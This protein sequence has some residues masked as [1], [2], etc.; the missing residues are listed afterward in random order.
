MKNIM[1]EQ[2][3]WDYYSKFD[4]I[5]DKY[6]P[7]RGEGETIASQIVTAVN[8]L[9]YKWYNDG[10][11]YDNTKYLKGWAN[12]L[13]SYANWLYKHLGS[14]LKGT[15]SRIFVDETED[16]YEE[17]LK[18][19]A[20]KTLDETFLSKFENQPKLG[21][22][23]ECDGP[24]KFIDREDE[25]DE[26]ELDEQCESK[27]PL[28]EDCFDDFEEIIAD[29]MPYEGEGE[30]MSSQIAT[31]VNMLIYKWFNDGDVYDSTTEY[32]GTQVN[33]LSSFAN[34]LYKNTDSEVRKILNKIYNVKSN[35]DYEKI[36]EELG[37]KIINDE[38]LGTFDDKPAVD[39]IYECDGPF[40]YRGTDYYDE[41]LKKNKKEKKMFK[42]SV[43]VED[44]E[45]IKDMS[46]EKLLDY[47]H[48]NISGD[49]LFNTFDGSK[50]SQIVA[51][52]PDS[53]YN[54]D[55]IY[56]VNRDKLNDKKYI[57]VKFLAP[58][59]AVLLT[60]RELESIALDNLDESDGEE[61]DEACRS[62]KTLKEKAWEKEV[63]ADIA[64]AFRKAINNDGAQMKNIIA[65]VTP[66]LDWIA[67]ECPDC[68]SD[69]DTIRDD[70][71][72]INPEAS[73]TDLFADDVDDG[74]NEEYFNDCILNPIYDLCDELNIWIPTQAMMEKIDSKKLY[75]VYKV[76]TDREFVDDDL[77]EN[78]LSLKLETDSFEE[79]LDKLEDLELEGYFGVIKDNE[80]DEFITEQEIDSWK[81][82][83]QYGVEEA[84]NKPNKQEKRKQI[85]EGAGAGY[86]INGELTQIKFTKINSIDVEEDTVM[87]GTAEFANISVEGTAYFKG[88]AEDYYNG[89]EVEG[90]VAIDSISINP[91]F[92][93]YGYA[94]DYNKI[95]VE[96]LN[97][98][99]D[100][101][102]FKSDVIGGG[103]SH[104]PFDG[105]VKGNIEDNYEIDYINFHFINKEDISYVDKVIEDDSD[106]Q[107]DDEVLDEGR[108]DIYDE[109]EAEYFKALRKAQREG[110]VVF[111][112]K[113]NDKDEDGEEFDTFQEAKKYAKANNIDK[114]YVSEFA[115]CYGYYCDGDYDE[116]EAQVLDLDKNII[117]EN[118]KDSLPDDFSGTLKDFDDND[119][120]N[121]Y[122]RRK[123]VEFRATELVKDYYNNE[124]DLPTLHKK[125]EDLFGSTKE[126]VK[127]FAENDDKIKN[128]KLNESTQEQNT[129]PLEE[130]SKTFLKD[131]SKDDN[132]KVLT[133]KNQFNYDVKQLK[134]NPKTKTYSVGQF[135]ISDPRYKTYNGKDFERTLNTLKDL[136][137]VEESV[138]GDAKAQEYIDSKNDNFEKDKETTREVRKELAK[139]GIATDE[140]GKPIGEELVNGKEKSFDLVKY[141]TEDPYA[142]KYVAHSGK[143]CYRI[144]SSLKYYLL[145]CDKAGLVPKQE[146][147]LIYSAKGNGFEFEWIEEDA[148]LALDKTKIKE[149]VDKKTVADAILEFKE[150]YSKFMDK[151][152]FYKAIKEMEK[153]ETYWDAKDISSI[154]TNLN[155]YRF[156]DNNEIVGHA[157]VRPSKN[158]SDLVYTLKDKEYNSEKERDLTK[159]YFDIELAKPY[160]DKIFN[161]KSTLKENTVKQGNAWVNKG[162]EGTHGKFKTK[163]EADAQR[164]AMFA[165][166]Y[167]INESYASKLSRKELED[168]IWE[169]LDQCIAHSIADTFYMDTHLDPEFDSLED[170]S[171]EDLR[172][173][174]DEL[175][176]KGY[177]DQ[178]FYDDQESGIDWEPDKYIMREAKEKNIG[179]QIAQ[180]LADDIAYNGPFGGD[181]VIAKGNVLELESQGPLEIYR[182]NND[183]SVDFV[184]IKDA[185]NGWI[186]EGEIDED[187]GDFMIEEYDHFDSV[188]DLIGC[189]LSWF[190]DI[191][192]DTI[193]AIKKLLKDKE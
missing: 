24:F 15:L 79:A 72:V 114:I 113:E 58:K 64:T 12:D 170:K 95:T 159:M 166:G 156:K 27:K 65:G 51:D 8:K 148:I 3:M 153:A 5:L 87:L 66:L 40:E 88:I 164:K 172:W 176:K 42:E 117:T 69:V 89:G 123:S 187:E 71:Q 108:A 61:L 132:E 120:W 21:S 157:G 98:A 185:V 128:G 154:Y 134:A 57:F 92:I 25:E 82:A 10:D 62:K 141:I 101:I 135:T 94:D 9:V 102:K 110:T 38:F 104:V 190:M 182:F 158:K 183:G 168:T 30:T 193:E 145:L 53:I 192:D 93:D 35:E 44:I 175:N 52:A 28:K 46:D 139:Q 34:W 37:R 2:V 68:E 74:T 70:L 16:D 26:E 78:E 97:N 131:L 150:M 115:I 6:L 63:P 179:N 136:G 59:I 169:V 4:P 167:K 130:A 43:S 75:S 85:N 90:E 96:D 180:L 32:F 144:F 142:T 171:D 47:V 84:I 181:P 155:F 152:T 77:K 33:D 45:D 41:S 188:L 178:Q 19:L 13:S 31:A 86:N 76:T 17:T 125:L 111:T 143:T 48:D 124:F 106:D 49:Y 189:G 146:D 50:H 22:I 60:R 116:Y 103:W 177:L 127:W 121:K 29:Y 151:D 80:V 14:V 99:F 100:N 36:L 107:Y 140:Q 191:N 184:N 118:L 18:E 39:S 161:K 83:K 122:Q 112:V 138:E 160:I 11:V 23:Y 174:V 54:N 165:Q 55:S 119:L 186:E 133:H 147:D 91:N 56:I 129:K 126:A 109:E 20:D 105:K 81:L 137:Y 162:K 163:K 173:I 1:K 149:S 67:K 73:S 7:S